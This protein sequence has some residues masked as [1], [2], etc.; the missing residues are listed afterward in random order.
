MYASSPV[1][2]PPL[3][4]QHSVKVSYDDGVYVLDGCLANNESMIAVSTSTQV[5]RCYDVRTTA[6]LFEMRDHTGPIRDMVVAPAAHPSLL[7]SVQEDT[8]VAVSDLRI[9][10]AV[11]F[12]NE[13][14]SMGLDSYSL[15]VSEDGASLALAAGKDIHFVDIRT[16]HSTRSI[17][18]LHTDDIT[19]VR[20]CGSDVICTAGEDQMVN[21]LS[22]TELDEDEMMWNIINCEEVVT[23]MQYF[24]PDRI[25]LCA[26]PEVAPRG[27]F[28]TVGSC[29]NAMVIPVGEGE[30]AREKKLHRPNFETYQVEF[31]PWLGT[32]GQVTG[33]KDEDG[34]AGPI[35]I[36]DV[37]SGG[38]MGVMNGAHQEVVRIALSLP[39][40]VLITGGEDGMLAYW[41]QPQMQMQ[42]QQQRTALD[43]DDDEDSVSTTSSSMKQRARISVPPTIKKGKPY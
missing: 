29:E 36:T 1:A 28:A 4:L 6:H 34:N 9:G 21:V 42:Q 15:S 43:G 22:T 31:V 23:R 10:K 14:C 13:M 20:F 7:F 33:L 24:S 8:G 25:P 39:N 12:L 26:T 30:V 41:T 40:G 17:S 37:V 2:G 35:M 11:H 18:E 38:V 16:W 32:L 5:I 3:H 27:V 19:R